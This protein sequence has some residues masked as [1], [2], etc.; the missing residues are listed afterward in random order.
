MVAAI[1]GWYSPWGHLAGTAGVG[2]ITVGLAVLNV[3]QLR[4]VELWTILIVF[5]AANLFEW[6]VH[7]YFMHHRRALFSVLFDRHTPEHHR[8]FH[9]DDMAI[10]DVRELRLVLIPAAGV[11]GIVL[12]MV[13]AALLA[14]A[15]FGSNVGWLVLS[16]AAFYVVGYELTHLCYHLPESSFVYRLP[17]LRF[18][19]EHHARHHRPEW[20]Q[21]FNFNVTIPLG[22]W[23][24]GTMA[25][26]Q[27]PANDSRC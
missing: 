24:F 9:Y 15:L 27:P 4:A 23:L 20:M 11:L 5:G 16:S 26:R 14:S 18:L 6:Y 13:P 8:V 1:P 19:R 21:R 17:F 12:L 2:A 10:V 22:D 25:P 7:R 3:H